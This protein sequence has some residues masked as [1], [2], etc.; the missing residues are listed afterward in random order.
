MRFV[1][2]IFSSFVSSFTLFGE[3]MAQNETLQGTGWQARYRSGQGIEWRVMDVPLSRGSSVQFA[4]PDW[5]K[6]FYSSN[7]QRLTVTPIENGFKIEHPLDVEQGEAVE[8]VRKTDDRSLEWTLEAVWRGQ[9]PAILEWAAGYWNAYPF[10]GAKLHGEGHLALSRLSMRDAPLPED[11]LFQGTLLNLQTRVGNLQIQYSGD[12]T[13]TVLDGRKN[14]ARG[15]SSETPSLWVGTLGM[16]LE[17]NKRVSMRITF[18]LQPVP[19]KVEAGDLKLNPPLLDVPH[20]QEPVTRTPQLIPKPQVIHWGEGTFSLSARTRLFIESEEYEPAAAA[21]RREIETRYGWQL[22]IHRKRVPDKRGIFFGGS[23]ER[24]RTL[25]VPDRDEAYCLK[26]TVEGVQVIGKNPAG[27]YYG[28]QTLC[29]LL[30]AVPN[31]LQLPVVTVIDYPHMV[32]RGVHLLGGT[33]PLFHERL[34][35]DVLSHFK[36][37]HLVFECEYTQWET[38]PKM[39]VDFSMPKSVVRQLV[40]LAR[41]CYIEPVPLIESLGHGHWMF[42]NGANTEIAEDPDH[43]WAYCPRRK[44]SYEFIFSVY[45]EAIELFKPKYFHIGHDE[46]TMRGRFP[47]C[48]DCKDASVA[49]L[50]VEDTR[51]LHTFLRSKG[52]SRLMMWSDMLL[53]PGEANDGGATARNAEQAAFKRAALPKDIIQCDWHYTP[54]QPEDYISLNVLRQAGFNDLIATTWY[55][56][57]NIY[58]FAQASHNR[59]VM[60][61]LQSTWAGFNL[62]EAT[63]NSALQQFTAYLLAAEY[64]WNSASPPPEE[65]SYR[66]ETVFV[67]RL[68]PERISLTPRKGF[69]VDLRSSYN[70]SLAENSDGTGWV[71]YGSE[72]DLQNAPTGEVRLNGTLFRLAD[73]TSQ[74]SALMLAGNLTTSSGAAC[75]KSVVISLG[76]NAEQL[77]F[78]HCTGWQVEQNKEVGQYLVRYA[79]GMQETI[80]LLYGVH[81]RAWDDEGMAVRSRIAWEGTTQ[82]GKRARLRTFTWQNPNP[83]KRIESV[84]FRAVDPVAAPVLLGLSGR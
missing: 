46:V 38:N 4:S 71:G 1:L 63:L 60:G 9:E 56:P 52:I 50:F 81:I 19:V 5:K 62:T 29:Q 65:L 30:Q 49:E 54:A 75:P 59:R 31:G 44:A 36:L 74:P 35:R 61:L 55:R 66:A 78:L 26:I 67:E 32:F 80:P 21:F 3:A 69:V 43:P 2:L 17:R 22:P 82:A 8:T 64:A 73:S 11:M 24:Q 25:P 84:E 13:L 42:K 79:D 7:A 33:E 83:N 76:R 51:R 45:E 10:I 77:I 41:R 47:H 57:D 16:P 39:W 68:F 15:W 58:N 53:A 6:G 34:I 72:H 23:R 27:A 12:G 70:V 37:N 20:L 18:T 40:E 28:A 14:P 48:P